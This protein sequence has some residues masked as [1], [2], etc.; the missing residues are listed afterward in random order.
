MTL[1]FLLF[2]FALAFGSECRPYKP[3]YQDAQRGW[4]WKEVCQKREEKQEKKEE[5]R[6]E[7]KPKKVEIPWARLNEMTPEEIQKLEE[8]ARSIAIMYPTRENVLEHARLIR[9]IRDRSMRYAMLYDYYIKQDPT[10]SYGRPTAM[11]VRDAQ[12][13]YRQRERKKAL[14]ALKDKIGILVVE[15]EGCLECYAYRQVLSYIPQNWGIDHKVVSAENH[16]NLVQVLG[17]QNFPDTFLVINERGYPRFIRL[18]SGYRTFNQLED[19]LF[20]TLYME[21]YIKDENLVIY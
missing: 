8:Q 5:V 21:G 20:L 10:L 14:S 4:F 2:G 7:R 19:Q 17:S 6:R 13:E 16:P 15:S 12:I 18:A 9:W 3:Y 1:W 11:P